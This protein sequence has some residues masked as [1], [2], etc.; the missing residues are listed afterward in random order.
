MIGLMYLE[1]R[2][3]T[4]FN[5][6]LNRWRREKLNVH[7]LQGC[8]QTTT[9]PPRT[10]DDMADDDA[11]EHSYGCKQMLCYH[12]QEPKPHA[13]RFLRY[14]GGLCRI[15][16][17]S[18]KV[19]ICGTLAPGCLYASKIEKAGLFH[20]SIKKSKGNKVKEQMYI[21]AVIR[22]RLGKSKF[23]FCC[24]SV[25]YCLVP[26]VILCCPCYIGSLGRGKVEKAVGDSPSNWLTNLFSSHLCCSPCAVCQEARALENFQKKILSPNY[27]VAKNSVKVA[28]AEMEMEK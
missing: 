28:P 7:L 17:N 6:T 27:A 12:G 19:C 23:A 1:T 18:T 10:L 3:G 5:W 20:A 9:F 11:Y 4:G 26:G 13:R 22:S 8:L 15:D 24:N 25:V 16:L 2:K 21:G 14:G